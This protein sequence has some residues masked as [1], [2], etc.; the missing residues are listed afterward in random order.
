[1]V[2]KDRR[3]TRFCTICDK[4][5]PLNEKKMR[6]LWQFQ[7]PDGPKFLISG[8][9]FRSRNL[10][11]D[12]Y[13]SMCDFQKTTCNFLPPRSPTVKVQYVVDRIGPRTRSQN[14]HLKNLSF[15]AKS[16]N[17][18]FCLFF[19]ANLTVLGVLVGSAGEQGSQR[20]YWDA[21][22]PQMAINQ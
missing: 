17:R 10:Y 5:Q 7:C 1:M 15:L 11:Q 2:Q 12:F 21:C 16:K 9:D 14:V 19:R 3:I 8:L 6:K 18:Y 22:C 13:F 4:N 20:P